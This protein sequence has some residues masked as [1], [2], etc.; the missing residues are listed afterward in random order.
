MKNVGLETS[1]ILSCASYFDRLGWS[2]W[3]ENVKA[4]IGNILGGEH[5]RVS[6]DSVHPLHSSRLIFLKIILNTHSHTTH[7]LLLKIFPFIFISHLPEN[8][9]RSLTFLH[10][11][12]PNIYFQIASRP[13]ETNHVCLWASLICWVLSWL[14]KLGWLLLKNHPGCAMQNES[15]KE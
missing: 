6:G 15:Y 10:I 5:V 12:A 11:W 9:F 2:G 8:N 13:T 7:F 4:F 3:R 14:I 1:S